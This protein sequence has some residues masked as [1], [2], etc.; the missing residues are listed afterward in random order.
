[1]K[2]FVWSVN[3]NWKSVRFEGCFTPFWLMP[4]GAMESFSVDL[5]FCSF[6][7]FMSSEYEAHDLVCIGRMRNFL[8]SS[9]CWWATT[10]GRSLP[11]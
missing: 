9:R 8:P 11:T 3:P 5:L 1:M 7:D 4:A 2:E 6:A 10:F